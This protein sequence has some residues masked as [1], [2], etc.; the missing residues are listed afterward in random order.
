[1][2][3]IFLTCVLV[4]FFPSI[5]LASKMNLTPYFG[6]GV[7][8]LQAEL[9]GDKATSPG[10]TFI[11]GTSLDWISSHVAT[12]FRFG[13]GGQF[14]T[15]NGSVNN[16]ASYLIKPS[17]ELTEQFDIYGL[18]GITSMTVTIAGNHSSDADLSYGAGLRYHIPNESLAIEGEWM[19]YRKS[20]TTSAT[21][22]SG[23]DV[24][25]ASISI[26]FE[27]Y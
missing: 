1:M 27:Y 10:L 21:S 20:S 13:F 9:T 12:E 16:Y 17:F 3:K 15:F 6:L 25:G 22:I 8:G 4:A 2:K 26:L 24:M 11:A 19:Q 18:L 23:M 7:T 14:T 5:A